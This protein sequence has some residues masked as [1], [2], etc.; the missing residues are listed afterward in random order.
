MILY[1]LTKTRFLTTAWS[2]FGAKEAGGRWNSV[3]TA[4]VYL[5]EAASLTMLET[6]VHINAP[7]LLDDFTLLSIDVPDDQ[8]LTVDPHSLPADWAREDAPARLARYGDEWAASAASAALRVPSALSPV[9]YNYL[10]NPQHPA[11]FDLLASVK[12]IPFRFDTRL[13]A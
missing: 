11:V 1:R 10:F 12:R 5:S 9:E 8:V 7:Q 2:G 3:G 4:M 6:L 13:K